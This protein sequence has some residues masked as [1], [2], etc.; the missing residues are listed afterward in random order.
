[1]KQD[2]VQKFVFSGTNMVIS[3]YLCFM[4]GVFPLLYKYQYASMGDFKYF[5]FANTT[6]VFV[7]V[8]FL[9]IFAGFLL[10]L[11]KEGFAKWKANLHLD[12]TLLDKAVL[13]YF[14]C[15]TMS[16]L[17]SSFK[18]ELLWGAEGWNMGYISQVLFVLLYYLISRRWKWKRWILWVL[19]ASSA[20]VFIAAVL[21]RFD[22]DFLSIYGDLE[23]KYKV[24]FLSTMGQSRRRKSGLMI[25]I[26]N[27]N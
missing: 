23:L 12:L 13:L 10:K 21:H 24:Q 26:S 20:V 6:I 15:T 4:L 25:T 22:V 18:E 3:L 2:K 5:T 11:K 16:F 27:M 8:L 1:M 19:L 7:L 14:A 9:L 17:F